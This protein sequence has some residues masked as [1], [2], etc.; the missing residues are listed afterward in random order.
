MKASLIIP[1]ILLLLFSACDEGSTNG[2]TK[3]EEAEW[4]AKSRP[5]HSDAIL[6]EL[7]SEQFKWT[8]RYSGNDNKL[9]RFDYKLTTERNPL[10]LMTSKTIDDAIDNMINGEPD[11]INFLEKQ[12]NDPSVEIYPAERELMMTKLS[13]NERMLRLLHQMKRNHKR[14]TDALVLDDIIQTD[15]LFLCVNQAYEINFRSKDV[16]HSAYFPH[17]R[18]QM[19]SVPGM[20]TQFKFT[21]EKTTKEMRK[22]EKDK[23]FNY[24]LMCNKIC[25]AQ[26]YK[27]KMTVVV[28][29][30]AQYDLWMHSKQHET[31]GKIYKRRHKKSLSQLN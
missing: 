24:V 11:G 6:V 22:T 2:R 19:N 1:F 30:T 13:R 16:I 5:K 29:G 28:L 8:A 15:T 12:L 10:A 7:F 4:N 27:M 23:K 25:G 20:T 14:K 18:A 17:F 26:H 3:E 9:G 31:F 21:P